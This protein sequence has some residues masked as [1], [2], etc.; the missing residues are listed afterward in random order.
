MEVVITEWA[1]Q[2]YLELNDVF[3]GEENLPFEGGCHELSTNSR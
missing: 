3:T 2:S 1:L